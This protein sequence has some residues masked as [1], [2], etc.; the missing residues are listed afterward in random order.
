MNVL[1]AWISLTALSQTYSIESECVIYP[2]W[3]PLSVCDKIN[4]KIIVSYKQ[5]VNICF[6]NGGFLYQLSQR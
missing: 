4:N 2:E 5:L 3:P 6:Q 1:F